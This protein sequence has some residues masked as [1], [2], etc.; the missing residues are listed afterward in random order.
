MQS[1]EIRQVLSQNA[2]FASLPDSLADKLIERGKLKVLHHQ[3]LLHQKN[4]CADGFHCVVSGVKNFG[5]CA[6]RNGEV[7]IVGFRIT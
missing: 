6:R 7:F 3:Q 4:D 1:N 5:I 2:W